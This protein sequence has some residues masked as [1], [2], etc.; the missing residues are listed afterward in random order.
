MSVRSTSKYL[1]LILRHAPE[2]IGVAMDG[3]GWV[4]I[5]ELIDKSNLSGKALDRRSLEKAV[6][7]NDKKRFTI[8]DDGR[9]IR[10]AQGHSINVE[11][12]GSPQVPPPVLYHGSTRRFASAIRQQGLKPMSRQHVHLSVDME[13]AIKVGRRHGDPIVFQIDTAALSEV[14][15]LFWLSDNNVWLTNAIAPKFFREISSV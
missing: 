12:V 6:R 7:E 5:D 8:S 3:N 13:T 11:T 14:G 2:K 1:S 4:L 10:A 15:Q 9:R